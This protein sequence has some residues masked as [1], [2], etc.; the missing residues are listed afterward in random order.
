[1][2]EFGK[3]RITVQMVIARLHKYNLMSSYSTT[4]HYK[5]FKFIYPVSPLL[6]LSGKHICANFKLTFLNL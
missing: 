2:I 1:M 4:L 6:L 3:I 5:F